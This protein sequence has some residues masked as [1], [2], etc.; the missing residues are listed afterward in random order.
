MM[1]VWAKALNLTDYAL[2]SRVCLAEN[3]DND[4]KEAKAQSPVMSRSLK[5]TEK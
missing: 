2:V 4:L 3:D 5:S 1:Y